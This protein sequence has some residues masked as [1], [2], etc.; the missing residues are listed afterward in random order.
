MNKLIELIKQHPTLP[1]YTWVNHEVVAEDGGYWLGKV[2]RASKTKIVGYDTLY[3]YNRV[4]IYEDKDEIFEYIANQDENENKSNEEI[5]SIVE[6]LP[7][8]ECILV[9]VG[10][11]DSL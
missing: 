6:A 2:W 4:F 8:K 1:I 3:D 7:W 9:W 11:P 10:L 5:W